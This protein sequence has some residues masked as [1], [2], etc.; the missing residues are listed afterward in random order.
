MRS[1]LG[2]PAPMDGKGVGERGSTRLTALGTSRAGEIGRRK[3]PSYPA[4][5]PVP[6]DLSFRYLADALDFPNKIPPAISSDS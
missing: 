3:I 2:T 5:R 1:Q 4:G 6:P